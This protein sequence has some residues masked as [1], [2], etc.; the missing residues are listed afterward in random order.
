MFKRFLY[1]TAALC[2]GLGLAAVAP[3]QDRSPREEDAAR[4]AELVK[5]LGSAKF[6]EREKAKMELEGIG[7]PALNALKN[8]VKEGTLETSKRAE[9]LVRKIEDRML[10]ADLL[11]PKRVRLNVKEQ[12]V[13]EVVA[14]LGRLSGYS[15]QVNGDRAALAEKKIT[16]D[17]GDSTFWEALDQLC[18]KAGLAEQVVVSPGLPTF[19]A[20]GIRP[21]FRGKGKAIRI[22]AVPALPPMVV[23]AIPIAPPA[24]VAPQPAPIPAP[25]PAPVPDKLGALAVDEADPDRPVADRPVADR[26]VAKPAEPKPGAVGGVVPA[27]KGIVPPPPP[28]LPPMP[29]PGFAPGFPGIE[30]GPGGLPGGVPGK[31]AAQVQLVPGA[32]KPVPTSYAGS[33]R[34][35]ALSGKNLPAGIA[36]GANPIL[37]LEAGAEPRLQG[38]QIQG[39]PVIHKAI[40]DQGQELTVI[41]PPKVDG[42]P[43]VGEDIAMILP[44]PGPGTVGPQTRQKTLTFKRGEKPSKNIKELSGTVTAQTIIPNEVVVRMEKVLE[45]AGKTVNSAAGGALTLNTIEKLADGSVRVSMR[46]ENLQPNPFGGMGFGGGGIVVNGGAVIEI[47]GGGVVMGGAMPSGM[48][49]LVDAKGNKFT[50]G[51]T[52]AMRTS[53]NNGQI[54]Q[55]V[56]VTYRPTGSTGNPASLVLFG[57]RTVN[58]QIPFTFRDV[59]LE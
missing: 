41:D 24:D 48:P 27:G 45:A 43:M 53:I 20:P 11:N 44:F 33:V 52:S 8:A 6:G 14:E 18:A 36:R 5:Q 26:P 38:F 9:E 47:R 49:D 21:I 16:L 40:D 1:G 28:P 23:P 55:D 29:V 10:A 19:P 46:L 34:L 42:A 58:I 32:H 50:F 3:T 30:I 57:T 4:V 56:T 13:L 37:V 51:G 17:T 31:S 54:S 7:A 39:T 12:P 15:I 25:A 22:K 2:L 35:R 59:P